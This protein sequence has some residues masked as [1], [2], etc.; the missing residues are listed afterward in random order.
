VSLDVVGH[1]I[2]HAICEYTS[3]LVYEYEAG[4]L[5]EGFSDCWAANIEHYADPH[6]TDAIT[7]S[8][9]KIG[10]ELGGGPLRNMANPEPLGNPG[11]YGG[12]HWVSQVG[13]VPNEAA[14]DYCGVH[15]NSGVLNKWYYVLVHGDTGTNT[16]GISY[17]VDSI[18]W[19]AGENILYNMELSLAPNGTYAD[20]R[21]ISMAYAAS[22][23]GP[24]SRELTSLTNAWRAVGVGAPYNPIAGTITGGSPAICAGATTTLTDTVMGGA[25]TWSSG[26]GL[27]CATIECEGQPDPFDDDRQS[28]EP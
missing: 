5:N 15:T 11:P 20:C 2:G 25:G 24:C 13:C 4:A 12:T 10:E 17:S 8:Y 9:W 6:E 16:L 23:Y 7:K 27:S 22:I 1:E 28:K 18:G 14:N 21:R 19:T 26:E 3:N